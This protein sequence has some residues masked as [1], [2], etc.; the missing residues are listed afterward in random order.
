MSYHALNMAPD[1]LAI[2]QRL[3][4]REGGW[5]DRVADRGGKTNMG[6]TLT[7]YQNWHKRFNSA[8]VGAE[9]L[10]NM[11]KDEAIE[12]YYQMFWLEYNIDEIH[13]HIPI[14]AEFMFDWVVN[15]GPRAIRK[16]QDFI[17][18][19]PDGIFGPKS[20]AELYLDV[21]SI[22]LEAW[23]VALCDYRVRD[24]IRICQNDHTQLENMMGWYNRI[25][26]MRNLL[27]V[28]TIP[29]TVRQPRA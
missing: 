12:I 24:C 9:A 10:M 17:G 2:I 28:V 5:S 11:S 22:G 19:K 20:M 4:E 26:K 29:K 25:V 15:S 16:V 14:V 8:P 13:K 1:V 23:Y 21:V 18:A 3:I 27:G 7:T 6:I